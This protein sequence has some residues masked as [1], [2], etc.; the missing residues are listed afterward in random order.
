[1]NKEMQSIYNELQ[2][3]AEDMDLNSMGEF[4]SYMNA[5]TFNELD[6]EIDNEFNIVSLDQMIDKSSELDFLDSE[7]ICEAELSF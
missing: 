2:E 6:D 3:I 1:M 4:E 5:D 7:D